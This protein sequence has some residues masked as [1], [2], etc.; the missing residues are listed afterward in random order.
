MTS[1]ISGFI[2][3]KKVID[4]MPRINPHLKTKVI[5]GAWGVLVLYSAEEDFAPID[6][7][8]WSLGFPAHPDLLKHNLL[9]SV[10]EDG[11]LVENDWIGGIP[12][13]YNPDDRIV[14]TYA[15]V[16]LRD[17][18]SF[19]EEGLYLYLKYGFS[20][21]GVTPF[22]KVKSLRYYSSLRFSKNAIIVDEKEEP[23]LSVDLSKPA[24]EEEIRDLLREDI[25][26]LFDKTTGSVVCPLSGGLDSRVLCSLIPEKQRHRVNTYTFG[27][28]PRQEK[29]FESQ[30]AKSVSKQ[31]NLRWK[32]IPLKNAYRSTDEWHDLFGFGT[33]LH[34]MNHIEFLEKIQTDTPDDKHPILLS[35][36][37]GGAFS[38]GYLSGIK[39][40]NPNQLY[41]LALTHGLNCKSFLPYRETEAETRFFEQNKA[42]LSDQRWYSV[43]SMRLKMNLLHYL[44]KLPDHM[45]MSSTSPYHNFEIVCKMLSLPPGR[46]KDRLWVRDYFKKIGLHYPVR[47]FYGDTRNTLN[48][49]LFSASGFVGLNPQIWLNSPMQPVQ[50]DQVNQFLQSYSS[51]IEVAKHFLTT[52][53]VVKELVKIIGLK[54]NFNI[55]LSAYQTLKSVEMSLLKDN[56]I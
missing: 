9:I 35:G 37:S 2:L 24:D 15:N 43:V 14:S 6:S 42:L 26:R 27:I 34:G 7:G 29:S 21:M 31:L 56:C 22:R 50:I 53:R 30:I 18:K 3:S 38:G 47:N 23:A 36:L 52:Q 44:Y 51:P 33:H 11:V 10:K 8:V 32:H 4:Y 12:V 48:R 20:V 41:D 55:N 19:D 54:N 46:Q 45:G 28:S 49:Q 5:K 25:A 13:Y 39:V 1:K 17:D 40:E 16:C